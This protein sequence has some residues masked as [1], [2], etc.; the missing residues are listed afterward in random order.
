[1]TTGQANSI[2]VTRYQLYSKLVMFDLEIFK[3]W[4]KA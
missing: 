3:E 2:V 4:N 1:M